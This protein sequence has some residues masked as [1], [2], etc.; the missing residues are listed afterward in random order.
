MR[1][2]GRE[3]LCRILIHTTATSVP[4]IFLTQSCD[5]KLHMSTN[6]DFSAISLY[7][8]WESC[9]VASSF[10]HV[11]NPCDFAGINHAEIA[12][13]L[14]AFVA[15]FSEKYNK[16]CTEI[17]FQ[18]ALL[19]NSGQQSGARFLERT[20]VARPYAKTTVHSR[21][22]TQ[23]CPL[24]HKKV[25]TALYTSSDDPAALINIWA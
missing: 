18:R 12:A 2:C 25:D 15:L 22:V 19:P 7:V 21:N 3:G 17:T 10:K 13:S 9:K 24:N 16:I 20:V 5:F 8:V 11:G 14:Q 6:C 4:A 23:L 1:R